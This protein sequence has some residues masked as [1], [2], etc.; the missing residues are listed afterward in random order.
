MMA[1]TFKTIR[2]TGPTGSKNFDVA[3]GNFVEALRER[4]NREYAERSYRIGLCGGYPNLTPP[5]VYAEPGWKNVR[6]V[7]DDRHDHLSGRAGQRMVHC[8]VRK[9]DGAI[10]KAAGWKAP[11]KHP[12]G[13]IYA[14]DFGMSA[15]TT[16][17]ANY[18]R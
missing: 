9:S 7:L 10:L 18:L 15:V 5:Q 8:F 13:S 16:H 11:A 1:K 14:A 12:R 3:L 6:I 17:G 4:I 2:P